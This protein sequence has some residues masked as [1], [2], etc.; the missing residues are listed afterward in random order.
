M[1]AMIF[2]LF[3]QEEYEDNTFLRSQAS[4]TNKQVTESTAYHHTYSTYEN[5][6]S[7][8]TS[9][10]NIEKLRMILVKCVH[11]EIALILIL[12]LQNEFTLK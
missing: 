11:E 5:A 1:T 2:S 3:T 10:G 8:A 7:M 6:L 9:S 12:K 4:L